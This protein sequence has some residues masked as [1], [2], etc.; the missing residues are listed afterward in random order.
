VPT[1]SFKCSDGRFLH[2]TCSDQHWAPLCRALGLVEL[3]ADPALKANAE[4]V[5]QRERVMAGITAAMAK[6]TRA[7]AVALL[8][9]ADV[10]NGPVLTIDETFADPHVQARGSVGEFTHPLLG[11]FPA[12]RLP[13]RFDG[14]ADPEI[15]RPPLL[16]EDTEAVLRDLLLYS[17]AQIETLRAE[18]AI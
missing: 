13:Y 2:I 4:R 1:A 11:S 8:D 18:G 10:P 14:L 12:L 17:S 3:G 16:G 15:Q 7:E 6:L 9:A 5:A